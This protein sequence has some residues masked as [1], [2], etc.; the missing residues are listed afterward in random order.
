MLRASS[1]RHDL[2]Q[3]DHLLLQGLQAEERR[4]GH[5]DKKIYKMQP[6]SHTI[7]KKKIAAVSTVNSAFATLKFGLDHQC[8]KFFGTLKKL[9]KCFPKKHRTVW[10]YRKNSLENFQ[11]NS[12]LTLTPLK[13]MRMALFLLLLLLQVS[14]PSGITFWR[15][16][17][18]SKIKFPFLNADTRLKFECS[19]L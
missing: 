5:L 14:E 2:V 10:Q 7:S 15:D 13:S 6:F 17:R 12:S 19:F 18:I 4:I 8:L 9:Q 3:L 11:K 16:L 1:P